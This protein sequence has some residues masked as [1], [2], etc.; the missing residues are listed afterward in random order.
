MGFIGRF[1][2]QKFHYKT[3]S[4]ILFILA[5][6]MF[7]GP[8]LDFV[9]GGNELVRSMMTLGILLAAV[10]SIQLYLTMTG[11]KQ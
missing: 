6:I 4:F 9:I 10:L 7:I 11:A 3:G 1:Y 5:A 2:E 8:F